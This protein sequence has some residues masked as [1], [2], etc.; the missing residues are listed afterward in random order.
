MSPS[1]TRSVSSL[2]PQG[3]QCQRLRE[4]AALIHSSKLPGY[5][6]KLYHP[7]RAARSTRAGRISNR[8]SHTHPHDISRVRLPQHA[9]A[10][11]TLKGVQ[12]ARSFPPYFSDQHARNTCSVCSRSP[13]G[14]LKSSTRNGTPEF[15]AELRTVAKTPESDAV[16]QMSSCLC[17]NICPVFAAC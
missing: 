13:T 14:R 2:A 11:S 8:W 3:F 17:I 10:M 16:I 4:R 6:M 9:L 12:L 7:A 15:A 1:Q 5:A